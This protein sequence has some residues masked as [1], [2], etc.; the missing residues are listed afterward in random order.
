WLS[1]EMG[2]NETY[3]QQL[4]RYGRPK[5][6]PLE[7]KLKA[8]EILH[9]P[10]EELGIEGILRAKK[11]SIIPGLADEAEPYIPRHGIVELHRAQFRMHGNALENHP[12]RIMSGDIL[13]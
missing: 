5:D 4:V 9:I 13:T 6:M 12:L 8:A 11:N 2:L 1:L 3:I 10:D 7:H